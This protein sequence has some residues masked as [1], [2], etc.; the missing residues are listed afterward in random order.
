[1]VSLTL[2]GDFGATLKW[3]SSLVLGT[4]IH[5][6]QMIRCRNLG[7]RWKQQKLSRRSILSRCLDIA[8]DALDKFSPPRRYIAGT[9][10][11]TE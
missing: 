11:F 8:A 6:R 9:G 3:D 5:R 1:M 7:I 4:L 2:V 10:D